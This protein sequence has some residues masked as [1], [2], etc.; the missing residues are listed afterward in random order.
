M[1]TVRRMF[2][3]I[4]SVGF[5]VI[6]GYLMTL[7][8]VDVVQAWGLWPDRE[9]SR[10]A[11]QVREVMMLLNKHYV[12]ADAVTGDKLAEQAIE[13]MV[14][15]LDP[16][17]GFLNAEAFRQLEEEID[18]KFGGIGVQV[19]DV[20]GRVTVV[21]PIA[22]TPGERAGI[23]RG[24]VIV[25]VDDADARGWK[26]DELVGRLR[27]KPGTEVSVTMERGEP[28]REVTFTLKRE[29]IKVD[30]VR[31]VTLRDDGV[32]YIRVALFADRTGEEFVAAV[33][34][35]RDQG[36]RALVIDLRN[37]PGGLL[38]AAVEVV[39]P[40]FKKNELV[41]YTEGRDPKNREE[42]RA[43]GAMPPLDLPIAVLVN[44]GSASAAEIVAGA[45]KDTGRAVLVGGKTFGKGSVQTV[46][47]IRGDAG[48]RVTTAKYY[49]PSG[50]TIHE[51][52][53]R[54]DVKEVLTPE[55][56]KAVFLQRLRP[57]VVDPAVFAERFGVA[58]AEDTQLAAAVR[59]L[60]AQLGGAAPTRG[61]AD[62]ED[63]T[64]AG[65]GSEAA[66]VI[67]E[68]TK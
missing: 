7:G 42:L 39:E 4:I 10:A 24:D 18:S 17:S 13:S 60:H 33:R 1:G 41:V 23:L 37:N 35:L 6:A 29:I 34:K 32:G 38:T 22:G 30:S 14:G 8:V 26:L 49:T 50:V 47:P 55:Q 16:Y 65:A 31:D 57:D 3:R 36:M 66:D 63:D 19:E 15:A 11:A 28:A 61:G 53:I 46:I 20:E 9:T 25:K 51:R 12:D 48:L 21:A 59:E 52:G 43:K 56:E 68:E 62:D 2:K 5:G 54:P 58:M 27:G 64:D 45:L 44:G 40:F 67:E